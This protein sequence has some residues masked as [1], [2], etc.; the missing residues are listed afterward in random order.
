[1]ICKIESFLQFNETAAL[2][3]RLRLGL[4]IS[5]VIYIMFLWRGENVLLGCGYLIFQLATEESCIK[6]FL[7]ENSPENFAVAHQ[8]PRF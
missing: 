5:S 7:Q 2:Q 8:E 3:A 6:N 1:M 4:K